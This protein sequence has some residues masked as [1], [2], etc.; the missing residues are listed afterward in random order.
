MRVSA[1]VRLNFLRMLAKAVPT[2]DPLFVLED[3]RVVFL[4]FGD[5]LGVVLGVLGEL[6][7]RRRYIVFI[8][9]R[10]EDDRGIGALDDA[11]GD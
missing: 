1:G 8:L 10:K 4:F 11:V 7:D 5:L 9:S 6:K 3:E 2:K